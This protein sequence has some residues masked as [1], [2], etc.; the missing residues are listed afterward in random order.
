MIEA[1]G[2]HFYDAY[3]GACGRLLK[4]DGLMLLQSITI[5]DWVFQDH[6]HSVDFINE[7]DTWGVLLRLIKKVSY[8][9]CA[10]SHKH[11]YEFRAANRKERN[12]CFA[13]NRSRK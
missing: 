2:H 10:Y 8:A 6:I 3:F 7:N 13:S 1:V 5:S 9:G 11:L 4:P 12:S